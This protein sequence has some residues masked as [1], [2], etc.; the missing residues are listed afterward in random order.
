MKFFSQLIIIEPALWQNHALARL[1]L[2][3]CDIANY[4]LENL[5]ARLPLRRFCVRPIANGSIKTF[6]KTQI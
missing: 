5:V 3:A 6:N 2:R 4:M 1:L